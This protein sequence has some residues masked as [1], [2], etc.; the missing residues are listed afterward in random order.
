M[1]LLDLKLPG[2]DGMEVLRRLRSGHPAASVVL[3][4]AHGSVEAAV[5]AMKLG[6]VDFLQ[7][8]FAP[9]EIRDLVCKILKR[10]KASREQAHDY[11]YFVERARGGI[12]AGAVPAAI[13]ELKTAVGI[14]PGRPEAFN[15]L[16]VAYE[17]QM[18]PDTATKFYR[19][20]YWLDPAYA[21]SRHNIERITLGR[22]DAE[23]DAGEGIKGAFSGTPPVESAP[24][25]PK[26]FPSIVFAPDGSFHKVIVL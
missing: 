24:G 6:A 10:Q 18:D 19:T 21:P 5:E 13:E 3:L 8:P 12:R 22:R 2:M 11:G 1:V 23:S 15:L 17:R 7:K 26:V 25:T 9:Q 14:D 4:T 20:A 16:G